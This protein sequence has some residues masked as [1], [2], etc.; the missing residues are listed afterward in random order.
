MLRPRAPARRHCPALRPRGSPLSPAPAGAA[1][2][3]FIGAGVPPAGASAPQLA[4]A[5]GA[6]P[7]GPLTRPAVTAGA[8]EGC[9]AAY[10]SGFAL[11]GPFGAGCFFFYFFHFFFHVSGAFCPQL[12]GGRASPRPPQD[13][14]LRR[15]KGSSRAG[16]PLLLLLFPFHR[17]GF[18]DFGAFRGSPLRASPRLGLSIPPGGSCRQSWPCRA[19]VPRGM[20][21]RRRGGDGAH[22]N[23][24]WDAGPRA[25]GEGLAGGLLPASRRG[26]ALRW[27]ARQDRDAAA[28]P[29]VSLPHGAVV[30]EG[31][32]PATRPRRRFPWAG[33]GS[34]ASSPPRPCC[35]W[36]QRGCV[37]YLEHLAAA[38]ELLIQFSR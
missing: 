17:G 20:A 33:F 7:R 14:S 11:H 18:A 38:N 30:P 9:G 25:G 6:Q 13:K 2:G 21:A 37:G 29:R 24:L 22:R 16:P 31:S 26:S 34:T 15:E 12:R 19:G 4:A 28:A 3:R 36:R 32:P 35:S 1:G 23:A 27:R 10:L 5:L 8:A